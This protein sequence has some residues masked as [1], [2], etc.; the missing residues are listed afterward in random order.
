MPLDP[1]TIYG[2]CAL[3]GA[4]QTGEWPHPLGEPCPQKVLIDDAYI[5][6]LR[7]QAESFERL[8]PPSWTDLFK[9]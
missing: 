1:E 8:R 2:P 5:E 3:C 7:A 4:V 6:M 9:R